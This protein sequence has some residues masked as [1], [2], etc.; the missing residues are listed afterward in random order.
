V[1]SRSCTTLFDLFLCD[2]LS[3]VVKAPVAKA[4]VWRARRRRRALDG[5]SNY[6]GK[7]L[8]RRNSANQLYG[9]KSHTCHAQCVAGIPSC[10]LAESQFA[11]TK[12][13]ERARCYAPICSG[14]AETHQK[15]RQRKARSWSDKLSS[16]ES[17]D[18]EVIDNKRYAPHPVAR[19][20]F[21]LLPT[22]KR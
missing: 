9:C 7:C 4:R 15:L 2:A 11:A 12:G 8:H 13:T 19:S 1:H 22:D 16:L 21:T 14:D 17:L 20:R 6:P 10:G 5:Q 3:F 18:Y